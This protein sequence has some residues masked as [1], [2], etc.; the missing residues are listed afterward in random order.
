VVLTEGETTTSIMRLDGITGQ[1]YPAYSQDATQVSLSNPVVHTDGTIF[2]LQHT[3]GVGNQVIGI[4]PNSGA[5]KFTVPVSDIGEPGAP[6]D[7]TFCVDNP[8]QQTTFGSNSTTYGMIVAGDGYAYVPYSY[9]E[10]TLDCK[11]AAGWISAT[12]F[13][14]LRLDSSGNFDRMPIQDWMDPRPMLGMLRSPAAN[15]VAQPRGAFPLPQ[16]IAANLVTNADT[17]ILLSWRVTEGYPSQVPPAFYLG[18]STG[19]DLNITSGGPQVGG[20][21]EAIVPVLQA[22]DG[23]FVGTVGTGDSG[24]TSQHNMIAFDQSGNVR[25]SVAGERPQIATEDGGLIGQSGITYDQNGSATG[26]GS[27]RIQ[28]WTGNG[29]SYSPIDRLV[30]TPTAYAATF[31]AISGGNPSAAAQNAFQGTAQSVGGTYL[32]PE[33]IYMRSFAP[34]PFFGS[35]PLAACLTYCFYGDNRS[36]STS[37]AVTARVTGILRF[38]MPGALLGRAWAFSNE[39]Q[40]TS[41]NKKT[42]IPT[43]MAAPAAVSSGYTLHME[44]AGSNPLFRGSPDIDTKLNFTP[45]LSSGQICYSGHLYGDAFPNAEV[46]ELNSAGQ[47]TMLIT[48]ATSGGPNFGPIKLIGSN[49]SDMGSF[50][51]VCVAR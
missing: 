26:P 7:P 15:A 42:G 14:L 24:Y 23:S 18:I 41:G 11:L 40:D 43:I 33:K 51:N 16:T 12:H 37:L 9:L 49:D 22:Q 19:T 4:D 20:Q 44:F 38:W 48:F 21:T 1:P 36:F 6:S 5:Q 30:F 39:S 29:Y 35:E 31:A 17:G 28:S 8:G 46:F 2:V 50:A 10:D 47:V 13:R 32:I 27:L 3:M 45:V 25:W 34:W